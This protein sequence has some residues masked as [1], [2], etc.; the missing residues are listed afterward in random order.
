[1]N[2]WHKIIE[3]LLFVANKPLSVKKLAEI[4][5]K[6]TEE[7]KQLIERLQDEYRLDNRPFFIQ[8]VSGGFS[9]ATKPEYS[10]W[11]KKLFHSERKHALSK[12]SIETLAIIAYNQPITRLEIEK[13]RGVDCS[14]VLLNLLKNSLIK[15]KG[16]KKAPGNPFQYRVTEKFLLRF[17]L[18]D[19][20]DLPPL[21]ELEIQNEKNEIT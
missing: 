2:K 18:R 6:S 3:I 10:Q 16:R 4:T 14:T 9:I 13:I 11:V 7:I 15:I 17:G 21:E 8:E 1:V 20:T 5:E 19:M 12:A